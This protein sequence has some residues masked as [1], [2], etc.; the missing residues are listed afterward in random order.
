[1]PNP[2]QGQHITRDINFTRWLFRAYLVVLFLVPLPL[3]SNR[4]LFWAVFVAAIAALAFVWALGW[5]LGVARWPPSAGR[6]KWTLLAL[7][8][9]CAWAALQFALGAPLTW[10]STEIF[11]PPADVQAAADS[12]MLSIGFFLLAILTI[13]LVRSKRRGN[14]ASAD[15]TLVPEYFVADDF[16]DRFRRQAGF[17]NL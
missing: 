1:M 3:G 15:R 8:V 5:L 9:F 12:L 4:P 14:Q 2:D 7:G 11:S 16:A 17:C 13:L 10:L 6:A